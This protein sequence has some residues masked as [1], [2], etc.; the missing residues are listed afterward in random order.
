MLMHHA[1]ARGDRVARAPTCDVASIHFD[2][3]RIGRIETAENAHQR[4]FAR[5]VLADERVHFATRD[6][7]IRSAIGTDSPER[8]FD[9]GKAYR[10]AHRV[11]GTLIR[12]SMMSRR[13]CSRRARTVGGI[14]RSLC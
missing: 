13:S 1:D 2:D 14:N 8:L 4:G 7:E 3:A 10:V 6:L 9:A 12:P 5:A 11:L